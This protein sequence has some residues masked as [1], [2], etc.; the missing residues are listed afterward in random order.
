LLY[1]IIEEGLIEC[2]RT[3]KAPQGDKA[4]AWRLALKKDYR[5]LLSSQKAFIKR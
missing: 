1:A 2:F 3:Q 5:E 4:L